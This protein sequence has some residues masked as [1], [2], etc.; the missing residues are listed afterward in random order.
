MIIVKTNDEIRIMRKAGEIARVVKQALLQKAQIGV[1]T[2]YLDQ[3]AKKI[4]QES[5]AQ[6]SFKGYRGF[7]KS[8]VVCVNEEVVHGIPSERKL[9]AGD[10]LTIDLGVYYQGFHVDTAVTIEVGGLRVGGGRLRVENQK[11]L[12]VGKQALSAAIHQ[13]VQGKRVG[14]ISH[15]IQV[16]VEKARFSVVRSF[17]GH[18]VGRQLHES[19]QIPCF[20][21]AGKG[22]MLKENMT[23]AVEVMYVQGSPEVEILKD[24][25]TMATK[26]GKLS[27]M[28]EETV[29]VGKSNPLFLT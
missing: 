26:D 17:V 23:L 16:V 27:G 2:N 9:Q 11:F 24:G 13:C 8:I 22:L 14:D 19:P 1:T 7:P 5:Y 28:F 21:D 25:W 20:G 4:I 12:E 10:L 18:G 29:V 6:P 15:A 3:L